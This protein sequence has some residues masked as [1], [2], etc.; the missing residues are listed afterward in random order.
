MLIYVDAPSGRRTGVRLR[1]NDTVGDL[2]VRIE[3]E[4]WIPKGTMIFNF[5]TLYITYSNAC[6]D[7][8]CLTYHNDE[9]EDGHTFE[10]YGVRKGETIFL[11]QIYAAFPINIRVSTGGTIRILVE[12]INTIAS[13][14]SRLHEMFPRGEIWTEKCTQGDLTNFPYRYASADLQRTT[15]RG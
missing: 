5:I 13:L 12:G 10:F 7:R 1:P 8:Q 2:K 15:V 14:N 11:S 6:I 9:L 4:E 3:D